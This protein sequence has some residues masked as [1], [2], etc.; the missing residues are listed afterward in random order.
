[1]LQILHHILWI[2]YLL[3]IS[4]KHLSNTPWNILV[5]S[6]RCDH[7]YECANSSAISES[8]QDD[9]V[10]CNAFY[11]CADSHVIEH[12]GIWCYNF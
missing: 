8:T 2:P 3:V 5:L 9:H 1:M 4:W 6:I 12:T 7:A 11:S 10:Y